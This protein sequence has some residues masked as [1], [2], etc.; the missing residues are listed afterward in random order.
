MRRA[1]ARQMFIL[2]ALSKKTTIKIQH[3]SLKTTNHKLGEVTESSNHYQICWH[4]QTLLPLHY[5]I[6]QLQKGIAICQS[7]CPMKNVQLELKSSL[8]HLPNNN[9]ALLL[10]EQTMI[11]HSHRLPLHL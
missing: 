8:Y 1:S 6:Y 9:L 5:Q 4:H 11:L 7:Y 3:V 10:H 2:I